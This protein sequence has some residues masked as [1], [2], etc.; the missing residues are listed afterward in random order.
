[1]NGARR[2]EPVEESEKGRAAKDSV[3][4]E[5]RRDREREPVSPD[6]EVEDRPE[7]AANSYDRKLSYEADVNRV[8][9][10]IVNTRD[11]EVLLR[12]P[13]ESTAK[14]LEQ[15]TAQSEEKNDAKS[16]SRI[17]EII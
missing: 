4:R 16:A 8:Y 5:E 10:D 2:V 6:R 11:D 14:Y 17:L 3:L 13:S 12:L 7:V 1:M 9:L 15:V